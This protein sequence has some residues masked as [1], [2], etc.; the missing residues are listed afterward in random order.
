M[1]PLLG[2]LISKFAE[3]KKVTSAQIALA[4]VLA[5]KPWTVPIPVR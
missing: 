5:Q 2:P 4:W 1:N 3:Q